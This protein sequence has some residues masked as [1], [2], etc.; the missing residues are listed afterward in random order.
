[1]KKSSCAM[2]GLVITNPNDLINKTLFV[3]CT[4]KCV[5]SKINIMNAKFINCKFLLPI[6]NSIIESCMFFSC[7]F[8]IK[9]SDTI[10]NKCKFSSCTMI[11][12]DFSN[13]VFFDSSL[14]F[15]NL[16]KSNFSTCKLN[17][18]SM[19]YSKTIDCI[20]LNLE[21]NKEFEEDEEEKDTEDKRYKE[22][23]KSFAKEASKIT[24][25]SAKHILK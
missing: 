16:S 18:T 14:P 2:E 12:I 17:N 6:K 20:G 9:I 4:I 25:E 8:K 3:D 7:S 15:S 21:D 1:M 23:M 19:Y 10:F 24:I 22:Y 11:N 13:T 5:L